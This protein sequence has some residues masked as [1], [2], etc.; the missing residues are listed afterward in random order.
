MRVVCPQC[1]V[2]L[3]SSIVEVD[4]GAYSRWKLLGARIKEAFP[5]M[6]VDEREVLMTGIHPDCWKEMFPKEKE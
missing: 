3:K 2:C 1:P 5:E 4:G 6:S